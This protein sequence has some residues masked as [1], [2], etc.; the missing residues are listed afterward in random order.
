[1]WLGQRLAKETLRFRSIPP[2]RE[3]EVDRLA[4]FV[5]RTVKVGPPALYL[6]IGL[7]H[8]LRA[9]AHSQMRPDPLLQF[10]GKC[11]NPPEVRR[12]I[13]CYPTVQQHKREVATADG[14]HQV[15]PD[16]PQDHLRCELPP[17]ERLTLDH[18]RP[19]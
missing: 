6:Y 18:H 7:V 4:A 15:P 3:Q 12:V 11:L 1:M 10:G 13:H 19:A 9:A 8:T 2:G 14:E 17:L 16:S 5:D